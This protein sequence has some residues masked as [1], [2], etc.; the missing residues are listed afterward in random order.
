MPAAI[1]RID[2]RGYDFIVSFNY[3][4]ANGARSRNDARH[5]S[6][7][8]TPLRYAWTDLDIS[9]RRTRRNPILERYM[10]NFRAWDRLAASRVHDFAT[11]SRTVAQR[12]RVAYGR[13]ARVIHPPIE[14]TR[15][16]P[17]PQR[18]NHFITVTRLVPHKRV[19]LLV[20]SF[21]QLNLPLLIVGDGP[22]LPRLKAMS[23]SNVEFLGFQSDEKVAELLGSARAFVSAAEEDFG[24]AIVEA[25]AAGCS[26]IA[27]GSGG[28]LETV[29]EGKTGVLFSEQS[30]SCIMDAVERFGRAEASFLPDE[31]VTNAER[32]GK[33]RFVREFVEFVQV[34][35]AKQ[36]GATR[37]EK[38]N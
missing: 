13:E 11:N 18:E 30:T 23:K 34:K 2:L 32:F 4:V 3:A 6:Y 15:F 27:Y 1:K 16:C 5:V 31:S 37:P 7:T 21:N 36:A 38:A 35:S 29:I 28:A 25:Q 9:G 33:D 26:V 17:S 19:D 8:H 22:E 24:I 14:V 12:I 10:Q 20:Q